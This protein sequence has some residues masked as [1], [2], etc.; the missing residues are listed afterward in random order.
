MM[1]RK[2]RGVIGTAGLNKGPFGEGMSNEEAAKLMDGPMRGCTPILWEKHHQ[3][4]KMGAAALRRIGSLEEENEALKKRW[5]DL[6]TYLRPD[7]HAGAAY[8]VWNEMD[9]LEGR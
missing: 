9:R 5:E 1:N 2:C 7:R 6:R 3:A 4:L 8:C